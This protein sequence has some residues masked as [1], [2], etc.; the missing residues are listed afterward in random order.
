MEHVLYVLDVARHAPSGANRQPWRFVVVLDEKKKEEVRRICEN[1][2]R[3]FHMKVSGWFKE[4]LKS[5]SISWK[6]SFLTDAPVLIFVFAKKTE[7]YSL[8]STWIAIGYMLLAAEELGYSTLTYTP[9]EIKWANKL[10]RVPEEYVLEAIIPLGKF[11]EKP[12]PPGRLPLE[13]IIYCNEW[14]KRCI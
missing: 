8:Q 12:E 14:D 7:P 5:R 9:S 2:E 1:I 10:L 11:K 4:W 13:K 6:K 3:T